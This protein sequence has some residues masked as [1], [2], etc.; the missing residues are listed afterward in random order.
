[1]KLII[2]ALVVLVLVLLYKFR[3]IEKL[4]GVSPPKSFIIGIAVGAILTVLFLGRY[5]YENMGSYLIRVDQI[6]DKTEI[7]AGGKWERTDQ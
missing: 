4:R 7:Y 3:W 6:T 1:M 5:K 2:V